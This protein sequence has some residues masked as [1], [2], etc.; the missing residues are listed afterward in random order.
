VVEMMPPG[1]ARPYFQAARSTSAQVA[2]PS[3]VATLRSASMRTPFMPE[4]SSTMPPSLVPKPATLCAPLRIESGR[5]SS[6][7]ASTPRCTSAT[8]SQ[9]MTAAGDRSIRAL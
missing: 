2:P 7:A 4:R 9:Q 3:T 1:V 5:P 6:R 8:P